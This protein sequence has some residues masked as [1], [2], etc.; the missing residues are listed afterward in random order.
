MRLGAARAP[1]QTSVTM[2]TRT[3]TSLCLAGAGLLAAGW[4]TASSTLAAESANRLV[5]QADKPAATINRN[6]YG[7]FSEHLGRCINGGAPPIT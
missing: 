6:I 2:K 5:I 3:L 7:H 1:G 4:F